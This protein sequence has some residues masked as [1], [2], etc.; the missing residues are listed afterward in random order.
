MNINLFNRHQNGFTL[1]ELIIALAIGVIILGVLGGA[2]YQILAAGSS[3]SNNI[4]AIRQVQNTGYW[5]SMDVQQ[6]NPDNIIVGDNPA[7]TDIDEAFTVTWDI[8]TFDDVLMKEGRMAVYR[9]DGSNL[10]RDYYTTQT[11]PYGTVV[12]DYVF[13]YEKTML[14]AQYIDNM[15]FTNGNPV[16]LNISAMVEGWKTGTAERTYEIKTRVD[17]IEDAEG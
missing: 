3:S 6:S 11:M 7:T 4:M 14:I 16:I 17:V 9:L 15:E 13:S 1:L 5:I 8:I 2:L 10:Y 12:D